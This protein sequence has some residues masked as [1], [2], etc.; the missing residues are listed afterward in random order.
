MRAWIAVLLLGCSPSP[1]PPPIVAPPPAPPPRPAFAPVTC[2]AKT[3]GANEYCEIRCTCCGAMIDPSRASAE[4]TCQPL[5]ASCTKHFCGCGVGG[6]C[7][8]KARSVSLPCA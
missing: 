1:A 6:L 4:Y 7:N 5:P 8:E 3:C 2:G